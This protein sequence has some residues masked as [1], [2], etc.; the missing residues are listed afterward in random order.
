MSSVGRFLFLRNTLADSENEESWAKEAKL[1]KWLKTSRLNAE[2]HVLKAS[3]MI[4][5]LSLLAK[6]PFLKLSN[7]VAEAQTKAN[8]NIKKLLDLP[9]PIKK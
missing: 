3:P 7:S 2:S 5:A 4:K 9:K 6:I 8:R 1:S